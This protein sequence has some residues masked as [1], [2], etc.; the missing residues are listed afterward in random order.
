MS[1]RVLYVL[2]VLDDVPP[3][4]DAV[5][6]TL[7][8]GLIGDG[9][10]YVSPGRFFEGTVTPTAAFP[11]LYPAWQA[12]WQSLFGA[13]ETSVRLAGVVPGAATIVLTALLGRR[14][15]GPAAGLAAA[16]IVAVDPA[17]VA[18]DGSSMSENL[19][20]PLATAAVLVAHRAATEGLRAAGVLALG[21]LAGLSTLTRQDLVLL[22]ALLA[23]VAAV[24]APTVA[25][26]P[27]RPGTGVSPARRAAAAFAVGLTALLVVAPWLWRNHD[28]LDTLAISTSSPSSAMAGSNCDRT[29]HG[30]SLGSWEFDCVS[31]A[32]PPGDHGEVAVA[33]AHRQAALRH[34]RENLDQLPVVLLARQARVWSLWDPHDLAARDADETRNR[35]FQ[36]FA[37]AVEGPMV[38][39]G[40]AG[41]L[42]VLHR[43]G[44]HALVLLVPFVV[45]AFSAFAAYGNP[46]F[47]SITHPMIAIGLVHVALLLARHLR[48]RS[49]SSGT[50]RS[51]TGSFA[52][53]GPSRPPAPAPQADHQDSS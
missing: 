33:D 52:G 11:P 36:V 51:Y 32:T 12:A 19:S 49:W 7:Q 5:W 2:D 42:L 27:R 34:V 9:V 41:L 14:L 35:D 18:V 21:V 29:Y 40:I 26:T 16:A 39:T 10:G 24:V 28:R 20:V 13:G 48:R 8:G 22:G 43:R 4:L 1:V 37:R 25:R 6:Y 45:V 38:L 23:V 50:L 31:E 15:L 47:N 17:M 30:P 44:R 46:R 53:P 3:G